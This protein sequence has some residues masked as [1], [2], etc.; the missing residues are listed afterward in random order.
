M[1]WEE[2]IKWLYVSPLNQFNEYLKTF[3]YSYNRPT[4]WFVIFF[5][6]ICRLM[7]LLPV[8][9]RRDIMLLWNAIEQDRLLSPAV[10]SE[11]LLRESTGMWQRC[12]PQFLFVTLNKQNTAGRIV[13]SHLLESFV[14]D[15]VMNFN[16]LTVTLLLRHQNA[17][18]HNSIY[19]ISHAT[20]HCRNKPY[21]FTFVRSWFTPDCI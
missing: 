13:H 4:S 9:I 3:V 18:Y 6:S 11:I 15:T 8:L 1:L 7:S 5:F 17:P 21:L 12:C 19:R 16:C 10:G 20:H 2:F 14:W